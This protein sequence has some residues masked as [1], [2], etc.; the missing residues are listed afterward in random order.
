MPLSCPVG[1]HAPHWGEISGR[2]LARAY[3]ADVPGAGDDSS[4]SKV[5]SPG[6]TSKGIVFAGT[7]PALFGRRLSCLGLTITEF[8]PVSVLME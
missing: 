8:G 4:M 3:F 7:A 1:T 6:R 2:L 5:L